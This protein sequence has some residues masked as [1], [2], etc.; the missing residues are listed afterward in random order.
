M[1][2][3]FSGFEERVRE[4]GRSGGQWIYRGQSG[5]EWGLE[6][7]FARYCRAQDRPFSLTAFFSLLDQFV[8]RAGDFIGE[9]LSQLDV[10]QRIALAQHHGIP[11]PFL[12]WTE[13]PYVA[14]FFALAERYATPTVRPF[15]VWALRLDEPFDDGYGLS[16]E[17]L[18][19]KPTL[20]RV[21]RPKVYQSR[22]LSR[23]LGLFT[24]SASEER[25]ELS[26][27]GTMMTLKRYDIV[28]SDW[29]GLLSQLHLMG[30]CG[31]NL[32]DDLS[33]VALDAIIRTRHG[34]PVDDSDRTGTAGAAGPAL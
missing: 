9:E 5:L 2:F 3:D 30:V 6:T 10:C 27:D 4:D 32:F 19:S 12:D 29:P 24:F 15:T 25:I 14:A 26:L 1:V 34:R 23:Q 18:L 33:G 13:S 7:S 8:E 20:V 28:G 16:A 17:T 11:T 21:I 22:R 31:S